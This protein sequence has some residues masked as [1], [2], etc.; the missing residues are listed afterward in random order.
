MEETRDCAYGEAVGVRHS[1]FRA[2]DDGAEWYCPTCHDL[3]HGEHLR[4]LDLTEQEKW[5]LRHG[6]HAIFDARYDEALYVAVVSQ[7]VVYHD[8]NACSVL[9][10]P[11]GG[12][13]E[14]ACPFHYPSQHS[15]REWPI[16]IRTDRN[17]LVERLCEHGV[18]HPDPDSLAY[19]QAH[20]GVRDEGAHGCDGCCA[21]PDPKF[22]YMGAVQAGMEHGLDVQVVP[23]AVLGSHVVE[24]DVG[25]HVPHERGTSM[26]TFSGKRFFVFDPRP[27]EINID[28]IAHALSNICRYGGHCSYFYSVAQ[29]SVHVSEVLEGIGADGID[30][31][32]LTA[33]GL[34]H[35]AAEAYTGDII[36]PVK[37]KLREAPGGSVFDEIE[38]KVMD[39]I[40]E[41]HAISEFCTKDVWEAVK[42]AD[43]MMLATELRDLH[44]NVEDEWTNMPPPAPWE[45]EYMSPD[46]AKL[47]FLER[48]DRVFAQLNKMLNREGWS[49]RG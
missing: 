19:L 5:K 39:A 8:W 45:I 48:Y 23:E 25:L 3:E 49:L 35:D 12:K 10:A 36:R 21:M 29:H 46:T 2:E 41:A 18:G 33:V 13:L 4:D 14:E 43:N 28:D 37:V 7:G 30:R 32:L 27:E 22:V 44:P 31:N 34:I 6:P 47:L 17:N 26:T 15:M 20:L 38:S 1:Q 24:S 11:N 9:D 40:L 16:K 42:V